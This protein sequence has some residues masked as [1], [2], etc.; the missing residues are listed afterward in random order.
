M[1]ISDRNKLESWLDQNYWFENGFI[2][3]IE[4]DSNDL[5]ITV[6]FQINGTYVAGEPMTIKEFDLKPKGINNWTFSESGF[7]PSY[8]SC[9]ERL[10]IVENDFGIRFETPSVF[11]LSCESI[12][13]SEPR[14]IDTLT[15][16]WLSKREI[17]ISATIDSIPKPD[18]WINSFMQYSTNVGFRIY[19]DKIKETDKIPYPDYCGFFIQR[20]DRIK[21]NDKGIFIKSITQLGRDLHISFEL[22]DTE[23][24]T[25]W[26]ILS[27]IISDLNEL[28]VTCGNVSFNQNEWI[29]FITTKKLPRDLEKIKNAW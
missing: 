11:E 9:I 24:K 28:K 18:F 25:E 19:G 2:S 15:K 8:D 27:K 12:D 7:N 23:L 17:F 16:P 10:D 20:P 22:D 29:E 14:E 26:N 1:I 3:K 21:E 5:I 13:I 4:Q 6:G